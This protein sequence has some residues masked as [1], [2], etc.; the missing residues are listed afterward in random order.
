MSQIQTFDWLILG[1]EFRESFSTSLWQWEGG[2]RE[3]MKNDRHLPRGT[4]IHWKEKG[5]GTS[6][7]N[8]L[9]L[10][11]LISNRNKNNHKAF[12]E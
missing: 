5:F 10:C 8:V 1:Y 12:H 6:Y 4:V 3:A 2:E 9:K 7:L 11:F